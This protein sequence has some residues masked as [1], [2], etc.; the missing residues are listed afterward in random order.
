MPVALAL[1]LS[2]VSCQKEEVSQD[3]RTRQ[4]A[5]KEGADPGVAVSLEKL[6]KEFYE[7]RPTDSLFA[8]AVTATKHPNEKTRSEAFTTLATLRGTS[9]HERAIK[10]IDRMKNDPSSYVKDRYVWVSYLA[11]H[12]NWKQIQS[13]TQQS[14]SEE[15]QR[16]VKLAQGNGPRQPKRKTY[17]TKQ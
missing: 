17:G 4:V 16:L 9:Y 14:G 5:Q 15:A 8:E 2:I 1:A 11:E 7:N 12:P 10:E 6:N 13:E 3:D